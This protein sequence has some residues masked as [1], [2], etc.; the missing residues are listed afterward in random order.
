VDAERDQQDD[1]DE[2]AEGDRP[3]DLDGLLVARRP[4]TA[5]A[6]RAASAGR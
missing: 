5:P 2:R 6:R 1:D 3:A 4:T